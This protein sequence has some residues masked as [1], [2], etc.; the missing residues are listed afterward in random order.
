[1]IRIWHGFGGGER[2]SLSAGAQCLGAFRRV[3]RR[4][5]SC[6]T[7]HDREHARKMVLFSLLAS[8]EN[9]GLPR[10]QYQAP[11]P[12]AHPHHST[13]K[14]SPTS[15]AHLPVPHHAP[16]RPPGPVAMVGAVSSPQ[17][18]QTVLGHDFGDRHSWL[19]TFA[20]CH[21]GATQIPVK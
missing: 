4:F 5:E 21:F 18:Q 1:M 9:F 16:A 19:Q 17:R 14:A 8:I 10:A 7:V 15:V 20:R 13:C 12:R 6:V 11:D 3:R 2:S